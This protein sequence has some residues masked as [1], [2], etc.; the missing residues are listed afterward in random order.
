MMGKSTMTHLGL[1]VLINLMIIITVINFNCVHAQQELFNNSAE[2]KFTTNKTKIYLAAFVLNVEKDTFTSR[3]AM[4]V[5]RSLINKDE[6]LLKD[7]ELV[8]HYHNSLG[9]SIYFFWIFTQIVSSVL[10]NCYQWRSCFFRET[11]TRKPK[12][13]NIL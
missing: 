6:R 1:S 3:A 10:V 8:I 7:Y 2:I 13:L 11:L 9:V 5:A 4:E 12:E